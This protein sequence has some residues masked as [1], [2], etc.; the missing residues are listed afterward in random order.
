MDIIKELLRSI[1]VIFNLHRIVIDAILFF[2]GIGLLTVVSHKNMTV[3]AKGLSEI[4]IG[5]LGIVPHELL[6]IMIRDHEQSNSSK[7]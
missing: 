6:T 2:T 4:V 3:E 7:A 5:H 1:Q